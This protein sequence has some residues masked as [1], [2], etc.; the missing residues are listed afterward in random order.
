LS[1]HE[2]KKQKLVI[3]SIIAMPIVLGVVLPLVMFVPM[4]TMVP[5]DRPWDV[6]GLVEIGSLPDD[7]RFPITNQTLDNI[8]Y[9]NI[10]IDDFFPALGIE[11][12]EFLN[13]YTILRDQYLINNNLLCLELTEIGIREVEEFKNEEKDF[14]KI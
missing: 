6:N 11:K 13:Y 2:F 3:G 8:S 14:I 1:L 7:Y 4:V 12:G 10:V 9:E 5:V